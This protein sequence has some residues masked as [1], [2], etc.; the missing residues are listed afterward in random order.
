MQRSTSTCQAG[1]DNWVKGLAM[2]SLTLF[3]CIDGHISFFQ[4][5][6]YP[7]MVSTFSTSKKPITSGLEEGWEILLFRGSGLI[8]AHNLWM[9]DF[10]EFAVPLIDGISSWCFFSFIFEGCLFSED[11]HA[12]GENIFRTILKKAHLVR[13]HNER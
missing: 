13:N 8:P 6:S 12:S 7:S 9:L 1:K 4:Q 10:S 11:L 3:L 2:L 5:G